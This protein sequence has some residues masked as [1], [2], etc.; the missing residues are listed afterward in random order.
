MIAARKGGAVQFMW[1]SQHH[2]A[3]YGWRVAHA[4]R[5]HVSHWW[6]HDWRFTWSDNSVVVDGALVG[7]RDIPSS[8]W[9]HVVLR[10]ASW[11][12]GRRLITGLKNLFIFR[13][14]GGQFTYHRSVRVDA[15]EVVIEDS[16]DGV[17]ESDEIRRAPR[18]SKR[19]V[20]S[21]D[22]YHPEDFDLLHGVTRDEHIT[23]HGRQWQC[24]TIYRKAQ[25]RGNPPVEPIQS[26]SCT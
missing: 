10:G 17:G 15:D 16:I 8:P 4:G 20:A 22:S 14:A 21:A 12:C 2:G 7:C 19:H 23:R 11:L 9:K 3:D 13:K 6:N 25:D 26:P 5:D 18:A 1:S 24:V